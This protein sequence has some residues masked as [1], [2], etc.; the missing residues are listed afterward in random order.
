MD[1]F[2]ISG[3][4]VDLIKEK[5]TPGTL[6][7]EKG[8]IVDIQYL[9][10][11]P[12]QFLMPGF[13]DAH[14]HIESSMLTPSEFARISTP[15]GTVGTVSDPHEIGNVLGIDGV[16]F[17]INNGKKVPFHFCF[18]APSCVP[19]TSFETSGATLS[20]EEIRTLFV[21]DGLTYLS[22][23]MNFPGVLNKDPLVMD[24][25]AIAK[26]LGLNIDG[27]APGLKGEL[28][29]KYIEAGISTDH[30]CFALDE[31]LD[32]LR[33]GMKI[34]IREGSAAKNF[35]A[36][37]PLIT[38][39]P[40]E[41]MF[42]SD[43]KHPHELLNGHINEIVKRA[44]KLKHSLFNTLRCA[45]LNPIKHYKL[46]IGLLQKG[47]SAD[48]IVVNDL[49][50]LK[51]LKTYIKGE[52]V[53]NE[54]KN[55]LKRVKTEIL[56]QFNI[57]KIEPKELF[58]APLKGPQHIIEAKDGE[59]ITNHLIL[60]GEGLFES[61]PLRDLLKISVVNRYKKEKIALAFVK[62]FGL[63]KGAIASSVAH[64]SHNIIAV[65]TSDQEICL[66]INKVIEEKGGLAVALKDK[67]FTLPLPI[68]GI[69][70]DKTGEEL[71]KL[72]SALDQKAKQLGST[73]Q[74]PFMTLSFMALLVIPHLKLSDKG[75]FDADS[76]KF[77]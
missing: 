50:E 3:Q 21:E 76:F 68:G 17:M 54:G 72:Y 23:M 48:F 11:A 42:C 10:K 67:V 18:G 16:R 4:I 58:L 19:A 22:E 14:I 56:N 51:V 64:D 25:I 75:L 34:L 40:K 59:L 38:S 39:H 12:N 36:L 24:K 66:A 52:L 55:V 9:D 57:S 77:L 26:E 53:A 27:H 49:D 61:D 43:D 65:G 33:F 5:I 60:E 28:A 7:I 71:A 15:H 70:S 6:I 30:E 46:P 73:L 1:A 44:L 29:K 31:A 13:V 8:K 2:H 41:V 74:A 32:K 35:E 45:S 47:D 20:K 37:H 69:I 63:K 62:G